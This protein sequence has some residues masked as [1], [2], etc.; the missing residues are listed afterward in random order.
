[1]LRSQQHVIEVDRQLISQKREAGM[2]PTQVYDFMKQF[3]GPTGVAFLKWIVIMR[4]VVS[5][6]KYLEHNDAHTL[7]EYLKNKWAEDLGFFMQLKYIRKM[8]R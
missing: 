3:Y 4:L 7:L 6:K 8:A 1:M 2:K 5:G